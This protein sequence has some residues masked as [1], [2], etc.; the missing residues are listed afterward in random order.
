LILRLGMES[1]YPVVLHVS[2]HPQ[3]TCPSPCNVIEI[4]DI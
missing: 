3:Q 2:L 4:D 1:F